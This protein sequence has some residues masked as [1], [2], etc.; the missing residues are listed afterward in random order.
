MTT[1]EEL[2]QMARDVAIEDAVVKLATLDVKICLT[3][4]GLI[5]IGVIICHPY[6]QRIEGTP[7]EIVVSISIVLLTIFLPYIG[8]KIVS[9]RVKKQLHAKLEEIDAKYKE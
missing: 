4:V 6:L 5:G 2:R 1:K 3:I 7:L 9:R 8:I